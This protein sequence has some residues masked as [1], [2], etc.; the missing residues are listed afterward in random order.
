M[1]LNDQVM[2]YGIKMTPTDLI[3]YIMFYDMKNDHG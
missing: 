3:E 2:F 1:V